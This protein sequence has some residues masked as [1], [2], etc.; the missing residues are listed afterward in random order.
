MYNIYN[1]QLPACWTFPA[2]Q[3]PQCM[4]FTHGWQWFKVLLTHKYIGNQT[5]RFYF[6]LKGLMEGLNKLCLSIYLRPWISKH[7]WANSIAASR[8]RP[9]GHSHWKGVW[10]C[11]AIMTPF[12]QASR[13]SLAYQFTVNARS[14]APCFHFLE[15]FCIFS[16]DLAKF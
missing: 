11:A 6:S 14:C 12:F 16:H 3:R 4:G 15:I 2:L 5:V 9:G 7:A 1:A 8:S 10:G 13:R